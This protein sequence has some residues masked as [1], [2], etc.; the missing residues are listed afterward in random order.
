MTDVYVEGVDEI[1]E[2]F[3]VLGALDILRDP[4]VRAG[5]RLQ[6]DMANYPPAPPNSTYRRTGTLGRRWTAPRVEVTQTTTSITGT[7]GNN[8]IYAP[9]VQGAGTQRRAF[10][11]RWQTDEMVLQRNERAIIEDME[12]TIQSVINEGD[13]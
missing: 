8:T 11:R 10:R 2:L 6:R 4:I 3:G 9:F 7:A 1:V 5:M 13:R 12:R